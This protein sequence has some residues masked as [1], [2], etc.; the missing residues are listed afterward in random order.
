MFTGIVTAIGQIELVTPL[1][2]SI[3]EGL[4][5][6]IAAGMLDLS[7]VGLGDSI[8]VQGACLTVVRKKSTQFDVDVS[9]ETINCATG[10]TKPGKVNLEKALSAN[11]RL[12]GH[13]VSGHVDGLGQV[14]RLD[15]IGES[16]KLCIIA[17][18]L[19]AQY[20]AHKGSVTL[21]GVSLTI[22][23]LKDLSNGC[24][25]SI[26][27]IPHTMRMTTLQHLKVGDMLNIEVDIIA[28]YV[29]RMLGAYREL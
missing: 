8:A 6:S 4:R 22:N 25:F 18:P 19:L 12:S 11:K 2:P 20:F 29:E 7:D 3:E 15:P 13:I 24:E 28:R 17:P 16:Y 14:S 5:L 1:G 10:L 21:N 9:R 27:L 23:A 26:N